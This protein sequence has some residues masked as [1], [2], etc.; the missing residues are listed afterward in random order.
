MS[1]TKDDIAAERDRL[2]A[3]NSDLR[4][5]LATTGAARAPRA[6]HQ[7]FLSEGVR[8]ELELNGWASVDGRIMTADEVRAALAGGPQDGVEIA[9]VDPETAKSRPQPPAE[10]PAQ[11]GV[12]HVYP[13][14]EPGYIDPAVA[15]VP[16]I[17]GPSLAD[18]PA[19][20]PAETDR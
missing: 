9:D 6:Q 7:F 11:L 16:G 17:N 12:T 13:S 18:K 20:S 4:T 14:V 2:R 3:E 1:E 15:G 5:Q 8:Q 10:R 19:T